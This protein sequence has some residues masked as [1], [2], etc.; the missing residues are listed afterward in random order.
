MDD[1]WMIALVVA[2]FV[3][4]FGAVNLLSRI[5]RGGEQAD[6]DEQGELV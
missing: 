4:G 6:L 1:V 5:T 3:S 2:F